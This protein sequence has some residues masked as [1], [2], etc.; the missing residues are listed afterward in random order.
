LIRDPQEPHERVVKFRHDAAAEAWLQAFNE[1]LRAMTLPPGSV[2][3]VPPAE[4]PLIYIVG[5]PRSGSTLLSQLLSRCL[6][7]G[8][9]NNLIARFWARPSIGIR[10]SQSLLG[11]RG[12][13]TVTFEST[14]GTTADVAGPHEF[15][16][17]WR[18]WLQ[19]DTQSTHHLDEAA[20]RLVDASGLRHALEDELLSAF[21]RPVVFKNLIC[22]LQAALLTEIHPRS[23]FVHISRD[24]AATCASIL[25]ARLERFGSYDAWWSLKPSTAAEIQQLS[26][27][28]AQVSRQVQDIESELS[29]E[30]ARPGVN[31][32]SIDYAS[33]CANPGAV[34]ETIASAAGR[35]GTAIAVLPGAPQRFTES[36]GPQLPPHLQH[37]LQAVLADSEG[38]R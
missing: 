32:L 9:V 8:Y 17:F 20:R 27:P 15:G 33:L 25:S 37:E 3:A 36:T 24:R 13:E 29:V 30:L 35:M 23:L 28:C 21:G 7:V 14:H 1:A 11:E 38:T 12:R 10:L 16:Y 31:S 34:V 4:L 5:A 2:P 18:H 6:D 26:S 19:L 22:G